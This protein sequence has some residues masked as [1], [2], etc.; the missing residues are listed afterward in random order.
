MYNLPCFIA[1]TI[2]SMILFTCIR[3]ASTVLCCSQVK[4]SV[5]WEYIKAVTFLMGFLTVVFI[6]G[7]N[8]CSVGSNIWLAKW[9]TD[10]AKAKENMTHSTLVCT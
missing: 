5:I 2:Y 1:L 9:S 4:L 8:G 3:C 7:Y 6:I 10:E